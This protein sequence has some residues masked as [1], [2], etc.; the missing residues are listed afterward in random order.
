VNR[1]GPLIPAKASPNDEL[2]AFV[3]H[4]VLLLTI[5]ARN[6]AHECNYPV[7]NGRSRYPRGTL[8][9]LTPNSLEANSST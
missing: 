6:I 5:I 7:A 2:N 3:G 8:F 9:S 1:Y 4:G